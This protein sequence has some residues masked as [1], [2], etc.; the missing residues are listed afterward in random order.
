MDVYE[1]GYLGKN[2][3][4]M[5]F[6]LD[7]YMYLGVGVYICGEEMGLLELLE[8]KLGW[9]CLKFFFLVVEGFFG[10]FIVIN[11]VEMLVCV[12]LILEMG[13]DKFYELG[14]EKN[15]GIKVFCVSGYVNKLGLYEFFLGINLKEII[16]EYCGG[17]F[18][19]CEFKVVIF[20]GVLCL[21]IMFDEIDIFVDFDLFK[22]VG[23]MLGMVGVI[24]IVEFMCILKVFFLFVEFLCL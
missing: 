19:G 23:F 24:V 16:Y 3:L 7:M 2:I 11:N 4:G 5:G 6:D 14:V 13:G 21:V 8:G 9:F 22:S 15:G 17:I 1:K 20:G 10:C 12:L 18:D